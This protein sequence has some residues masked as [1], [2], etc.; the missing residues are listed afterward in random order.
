MNSLVKNKSCINEFNGKNS[1]LHS[2]RLS[3]LTKLNYL[4]SILIFS[5][6]FSF[7]LAGQEERKKITIQGYISSL[8][9]VMFDSINNKWTTENLLHNRIN[10]KWYPNEYLTGVLELRNR[11]IFGESISNNPDAS[12]TYEQDYGFLDMT[13]NLAKG[14]SYILNSSID[15]LNLTYEKGK[16]K[17]TLGRQRINWSQTLV[18]NPNDIFNAYSFFDFD[19]VE[20]P[21]S[22]A[23]RL[24]YYNTEVSSTEMAFKLNNQKKITAAAYY[25][26][27]A[28][29]YD[30]QLI[31]GVLN[32][33]DYV[34]GTGW[35]GAIK[36]IS[37]RGEL[38]Y[39]RP[40][41]NFTKKSGEVLASV[42]ADFTFGNS[43]MLMAEYLFCGTK[44]NDSLSFLKF[45]NAPL[46]VKNLSFVKHNLILQL[47]Y[48]FTPLVNSSLSCMYF[49]GINGYYIGP[50]ISYSVAQNLEASF[51]FQSFGGKISGQKQKFNL[52][53]IRIRFSF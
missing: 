25:K 24:Q 10:L 2:Y 31:G 1:L 50:S 34:I 7:S 44:I 48:P 45:Y 52:A 36:T 11:F 49:P 13:K 37:F 23:L 5:I 22:D 9:N 47:S 42:G 46:T 39:F 4:S 27:N 32:N 21:G 16:F 41:E 33:E 8:Q 28:F 40:I 35:S 14:N 3:L 6:I 12:S 15:R 38:S 20:R 19:Y 53:F 30:F 29:E 17:A 26:F 43:F 18:W 51:Y